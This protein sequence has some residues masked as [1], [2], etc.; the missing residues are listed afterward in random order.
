MHYS[1]VVSSPEKAYSASTAVLMNECTKLLISYAIALSRVGNQVQDKQTRGQTHLKFNISQYTS[2]MQFTGR[3]NAV[4]KEV[5]SDD[6][7]KL[8]IPAILYVIQ[9]CCTKFGLRT[10]TKM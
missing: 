4:L 7:W 1:R 8:S 3:S 9:V 5:F 10:L 6:F 2:I